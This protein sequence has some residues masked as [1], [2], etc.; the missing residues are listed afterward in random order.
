[1]SG[2]GVGKQGNIGVFVGPILC[3]RFNFV[4]PPDYT[5]AILCP[6]IRRN[7]GED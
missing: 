1:M 3:S 5:T 7:M 6:L 4:S 2:V